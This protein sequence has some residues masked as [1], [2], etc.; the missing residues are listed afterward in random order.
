M[1]LLN[2]Q[3]S[4]LKDKVAVIAIKDSQNRINSMSLIH[5]HLYQTE[6]LSYINMYKYIKELISHLK[7]CCD[8]NISFKVEVQNIIMDVSK[9]IPI[10]LILNE[11]IT[12]AIK[13]AFPN[14][15][16]G[17]ITVIL[18]HTQA[19]NFLLEI[20]DNGI[21]LEGEIDISTYHSLG[22][23]LMEGLSNDLNA[24]IKIINSSGLKVSIT[25]TCN[26]IIY[27]LK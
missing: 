25:F 14:N 19:D 27:D 21:G 24:K 11:A 17:E 3:A 18:K 26:K 13:Y 4:F 2:V 9:A 7:D 6:D 15:R 20:A 22:M 23:K 10:G 12:N 5:Q 1:S 8:T 16:K